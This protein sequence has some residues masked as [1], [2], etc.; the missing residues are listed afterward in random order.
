[1]ANRGLNAGIA[2]NSALQLGMHRQDDV[3]DLWKQ[4]NTNQQEEDMRYGN[5]NSAIY[6]GLDQVEKEKGVNAK[7]YYQDGLAQGYNILNGD[8]QAATNWANMNYGMTSDQVANNNTYAGWDM[9]NIKDYAQMET[10]DIYDQMDRSE[11]AADRAAARA[12]S[13]GGGGRGG[14][15]GSGG[16][17]VPSSAK[18][19]VDSYNK[20]KTP[21]GKST[22]TPM[23]AYVK[24]RNADPGYQA[25]T[26][27]PYVS[28]HKS[29]NTPVRLANDPN[30]NAWQKMKI[31]GL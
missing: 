27:S 23:D 28:V 25:V 15:G 7:Q 18:P 20:A 26:R 19:Y 17:Y 10:N 12:A 4:R 11:R 5:E 21:K 30:Y 6:D 16:G 1:M 13:R 31:M 3:A 9:N 8:R 14:S 2:A 22:D 29:F 24:A